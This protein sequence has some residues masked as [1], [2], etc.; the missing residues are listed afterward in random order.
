[1]QKRVTFSREGR[2]P[3]GLETPHIELSLSLPYSHIH[4]LFP[5][6]CDYRQH[7]RVRVVGQELLLLTVPQFSF[8]VSTAAE[9]SPKV[10]NPAYAFCFSFT[11]SDRMMNSLVHWKRVVVLYVLFVSSLNTIIFIHKL[12]SFV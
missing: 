12:F 9:L 4:L 6:I 3:Q 10:I 2:T 11:F 5:H 1:M 8:P 7:L